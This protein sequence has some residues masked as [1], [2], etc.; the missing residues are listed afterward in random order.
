MVR[1]LRL[2]EVQRHTGLSARV[3]YR[4]VAA[5]TFPRQ[6]PLGDKATGWLESEIEQWVAER[7]AE[8][9]ATAGMRSEMGR[10]L[11]ARRD[12]KAAA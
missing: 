10:E 1:I 3:I 9:D 12:V 7:I 11:R 4:R 2:P 6:V 5:G 8:R